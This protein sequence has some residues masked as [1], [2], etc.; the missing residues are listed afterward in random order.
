MPKHIVDHLRDAMF[1]DSGL[2][3]VVGPT[4]AGKSTTMLGCVELDRELWGDTKSRIS[5]EIPV[6]REV[7]GINQVQA[8]VL[9]NETLEE[10]FKT[11]LGSFVRLDPDFMVMGEIRDRET[12]QMAA[13]QSVTG[14]KTL[15]TLH[16]NNTEEAI[17]RLIILSEDESLRHLVIGA[18]Q[19]I[20]AQRLFPKVCDKCSIQ[21]PLSNIEHRR[22]KHMKEIGTISG[23]VDLITVRDIHK[24]GCESCNYEGT[25]GV[26]PAFEVLD[27]TNEVKEIVLSSDSTRLGEIKKLRVATMESMAIE[28]IKRGH[29][30]ISSLFL[31]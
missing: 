1:N 7:P 14:H 30:P 6:E 12:A 28:H 16:A 5:I 20:I 4:G 19:T 3:L 24:E 27:V 17:E 22:I 23:D 21:R 13:Q 2:I 8:K 25:I 15:A 11:Y 29:T 31:L 10:A 26:V 9:P 18:C